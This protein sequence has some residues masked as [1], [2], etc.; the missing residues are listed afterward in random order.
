ML[1]RAG[2]DLKYV[3]LDM[4]TAEME[5]GGISNN[6]VNQA[7]IETREAKINTA[8]V[9]PLTATIDF[10]VAHLKSKTKQLIRKC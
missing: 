8:K 6:A 7:F 10:L 5:V 1:L 4:F 9:R 2:P 3:F